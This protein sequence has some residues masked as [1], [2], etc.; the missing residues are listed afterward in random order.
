MKLMIGICLGLMV[1]TLSHAQTDAERC[2]YLDVY[3]ITGGG[4]EGGGSGGFPSPFS[5]QL[6]GPKFE[7]ASG[8]AY[9]LIGRIYVKDGYGLLYI[10][11]RAHPW[12]ANQERRGSPYYLIQGLTPL[13]LERLHNRTV[14]VRA[15]ALGQILRDQKGKPSYYLG[16]RVLETPRII[17]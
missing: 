9:S 1:S 12:L 10:D 4:G 16:L 3:G 14:R 2:Q 17:R 13:D 7:L 6:L 15:Q 8:E 11:Y 5:C